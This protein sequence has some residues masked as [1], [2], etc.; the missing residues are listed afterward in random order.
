MLLV[1]C[2]LLVGLTV[3]AGDDAV[4]WPYS[5]A[6]QQD[7]IDNSSQVLR[8]QHDL[9]SCEQQQHEALQRFLSVGV[10]FQSAIFMAA[11]QYPCASTD[12]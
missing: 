12:R 4:H 9:E 11:N 5:V 7:L 6:P 3:T 10:P 1:G 8:E 2:A